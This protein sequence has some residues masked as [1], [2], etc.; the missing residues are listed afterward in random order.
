MWGLSAPSEMMWTSTRSC[1]TAVIW[2]SRTWM[3]DASAAR[4]SAEVS[5]RMTRSH[6]SVSWCYAKTWMMMPRF[7]SRTCNRADVMMVMMNGSLA[8]VTEMTAWNR[9][10]VVATIDV[11]PIAI[12]CDAVDI[13]D[14]D[15]IHIVI[16]LS[17]YSDC[18]VWVNDDLCACF[19]HCAGSDARCQTHH[20]DDCWDDIKR[21]LLHSLK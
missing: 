12:V 2:L 10:I 21:N 4:P 3:S 1:I 18:S 13:N 19:G 6:S 8:D 7:N 20:W 16:V 9:T 11:I 15:V 14:Y 17:F 5:G